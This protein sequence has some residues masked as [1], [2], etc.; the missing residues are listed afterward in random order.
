MYL[1]IVVIHN[2]HLFL[3]ECEWRF[4][5]GSPELLLKN[6][7]SLSLRKLSLGVSHKLIL[8]REFYE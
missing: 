2:F 6:L 7:K 1:K 8:Q 4:N 3:K 5:M